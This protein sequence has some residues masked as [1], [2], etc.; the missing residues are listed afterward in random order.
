MYASTEYPLVL[1]RRS[2]VLTR[3]TGLFDFGILGRGAE[4]RV[5]ERDIGRGCVDAPGA[6]KR[7]QDE[8]RSRY[9]MEGVI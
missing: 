1:F 9:G 4:G 6:V 8:P 2:R 7:Y 3:S 5:G